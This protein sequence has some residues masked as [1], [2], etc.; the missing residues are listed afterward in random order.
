MNKLSDYHIHTRLCR[1]AEGEPRKYVKAGRAAGLEE[2]CFTDHA[3]APDGY[4]AANRMLLFQYPEYLQMVAALSREVSPR[5]LFGIEADYYEPNDGFLKKW[6]KSQSFDLVLGSVHYIGNWCIDDPE[7]LVVW[8]Q[9]DVPAVWKKY[10]EVIGKLADTRLFDVV[11]HLDLP[12]KFAYRPRDAFIKEIVKPA[13]DKIAKAGMVIELNTA[14][15]R[16]P[17]KAIYPSAEILELALEREIQICFGS[18]AH[19]PQHVG[20]AFDKALALAKDVG[21]KHRVIFSQRRKTLVP[22]PWEGLA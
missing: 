7:H 22:L 17:A 10:F 14:G 15:L 16:R 4:D 13:L 3:P 2:M 1:H 18:D 11:S 5:I 9:A 20:F 19:R 6:L 21:F 8:K 12:K